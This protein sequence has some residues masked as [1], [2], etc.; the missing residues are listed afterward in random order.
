ML[1]VIC[2]VLYVTCYYYV[3]HINYKYMWPMIYTLHVSIPSFISLK[4]TKIVS[5]SAKKH[6]KSRSLSS[7]DFEASSMGI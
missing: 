7:E 3:L 6:L 2:Y 5:R 4:N 1:C